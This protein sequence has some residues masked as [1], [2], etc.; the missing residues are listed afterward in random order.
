MGCHRVEK[1]CMTRTSCFLGFFVDRPLKSSAS[2]SGVR[3]SGSAK[4]E[5]RFK[6]QRVA[7]GFLPLLQQR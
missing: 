3:Q 7:D 2:Q 5:L 6:D 4:M 1:R